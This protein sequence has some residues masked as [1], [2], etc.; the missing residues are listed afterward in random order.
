MLSTYRQTGVSLISLM[1]GLL[2]SMVALLGMMSLYGTVVKSTVESTRDA[3]IAG[4]RSSA[5]LV[6]TRELQGAGYGIDGAT[7]SNDLLLRSGVTLA[8][9]EASC[10]ALH[11]DNCSLSGGNTLFWQQM[12]PT[13]DEPT[14]E[15]SGLHAPHSAD[16]GG[17][18]LLQPQPQPC[19]ALT[20]SEWQVRPLLIDNDD[21]D[22]SRLFSI[23]LVEH[24][25]SSCQALGIAGA[26]QIS[27]RL[28]TTDR[29]G[30]SIISSSTC[31]LNFSHPE[32]I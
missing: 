17:L 1:I 9:D 18:Y 29:N 10:E 21:V 22:V 23:T 25:T 28:S 31:L 8:L 14:V 2:I 19:S 13:A 7:G 3:R 32:S 6:A 16:Q 4:E 5:L 24:D 12:I 30:N 26:G 11:E 20:E 27:V 15:C